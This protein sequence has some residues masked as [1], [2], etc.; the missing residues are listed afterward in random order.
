MD[1]AV[2]PGT[3]P[4]SNFHD[5][6]GE[7]RRISEAGGDIELLCLRRDLTAIPSF[8]F[9]LR[10]RASRLANFRHTYYGRVRS[11]DRLN[12]PSATLAVASDYTRGIRMSQLLTSQDGRPVTIDVNAALHLIR[13]LVS[14]VA[15]LHEN[16]RDVA[17]GALGP[18]RIVVTPNARLVIHE[19]VLGAA[20]E[21]LRFSHDRYWKQLRIA[22]PP[23][24]GLPRFDHRADVT[25]VGVISLSLVLGRLLTD[26]EYPSQ[27]GDVLA[28]AWAIS[29]RGG[30]EPLP[31]GLRAW[32]SRALQLDPR[33]SFAT[34]ADA[35]TELDKVLAGEDEASYAAE[36]MAATPTPDPEPVPAVAPPTPPPSAPRPIA[37]V[38]PAAPPSAPQRTDVTPPS[39]PA[40]KA[41][42]PLQDLFR[43]SGPANAPRQASGSQDAGRHEE[44][45]GPARPGS[46]VNK[47][48]PVAASKSAVRDDKADTLP[49]PPVQ[50]YKPFTLPK[51]AAPRDDKPVTTPKPP[52]QDSQSVILPKPAVPDDNADTLP[53]PPVQQ[54]KPFTLP[55]PGA[56]RDDKSVTAPKPPVQDSKSVVLPKPAVPDDKPLVAPKPAAQDGK[57]FSAPKP[58]LP[59]DK[60]VTVAKPAVQDSKPA[61]F[62]KPAPPED[63]PAT[64]P[65]PSVRDDKPVVPPKP[66]AFDDKFSTPKAAQEEK[67]APPKSALWDEKPLPAP[68]PAPFE[69]KRSYQHT[70][71]P[72]VS[73]NSSLFESFGGNTDSLHLIEGQQFAAHFE[74]PRRTWPK[75]L[76]V[77]IVLLAL[78]GGGVYMARRQAPAAAD[79]TANG[80][81]TITTNPKGAQVFV[82]GEPRGIS[83]LAL[84]LSPGEHSVEVRGS[85]EPRTIPV[86][87]TPGAQTSQYIELPAASTSAAVGQL[88]VRSEPAGAQVTV[89]GLVRGKSPVLVEGLTPGEHTVVLESELG[90]VKQS[91][92]IEAATTA[93]LVVPLTGGGGAP[94]SGWISIAAPV[95]LH[96]F[97]NKKLLGTT[98][99]DRILMTTGRHEIEIVNDAVGYR[100]VSV[101]QVT[102]GKV[103]PVKLEWPKGSLAVNAQPWADVWIDGEK[104]GE[105]PIGNVSL[106]IG[107]HEIVFRNPELGEQRRTVIVTLKTPARASADLRK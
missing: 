63:K 21:Q 70:A 9:A 86:T 45:A 68:K 66:A 41:P 100:A 28:A 33:H 71:V 94:L 22:L 78:G 2:A 79:A 51:P 1:P 39:A 26:D 34:V 8:E 80:V 89:D 23:S 46:T 69:E 81:L 85:G 30:L 5:G 59:E 87:I 48:Q 105:T 58:A 3:P 20:L 95:E 19:Y 101:V 11:I 6:L 42:V 38:R 61:T 27:I 76:A 67:P 15:M 82:D 60:A 13:Q 92:R 98:Q 43:S 75:L 84:S 32:L 14:A 24:P 56:H 93:S 29:A 37:T 49:K 104:I 64:L 103:T 77:A 96:V 97:E 17:H 31:Q 107:P 18:E 36:L 72:S 44:S 62:P 65:K 91:V 16:A 99:T 35:R 90:T 7:R 40:A 53:K 4:A 52:V 10:E 83:P 12:D 88:Q 25:Q 54:Y 47:D 74:Q 106:P 102:S 50:Q 73:P 57:P 55:K